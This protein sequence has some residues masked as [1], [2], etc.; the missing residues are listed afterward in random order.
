MSTYLS[1][2]KT[3]FHRIK[4]LR[5][6]DIHSLQLAVFMYKYTHNQLPA[7]FHNM[8]DLNCNVHAY[9]TRHSSDYHLQNPKIILA[10]KSMRHHGPDIIT[11][12]DAFAS[13]MMYCIITHLYFYFVNIDFGKIECRNKIKSNQIK[14]GFRSYTYVNT[15]HLCLGRCYA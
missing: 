1:H 4:S 15:F 6:Q 11:Y 13:I 14:S 3:L 2:N 12:L 7:I 10:Q 8:F 5:I 9:P